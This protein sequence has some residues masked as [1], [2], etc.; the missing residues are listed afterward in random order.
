[1]L[2]VKRFFFLN[3]S[4]WYKNAKKKVSMSQFFRV[5]P[6]VINHVELVLSVKRLFRA[7]KKYAG[8]SLLRADDVTGS[9]ARLIKPEN[10]EKVLCR[11]DLSES[12]T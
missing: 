2:S 6:L 12:A 8:K 10:Q 11:C 9:K 5:H 7:N 3:T 1:M 4:Q